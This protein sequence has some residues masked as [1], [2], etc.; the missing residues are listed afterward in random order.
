MESGDILTVRFRYPP[1]IVLILIGIRIK[2]HED[3]EDE[4]DHDDE[5]DYDHPSLNPYQW[6]YKFDIGSD[7]PI[8]KWISDIVNNFI[9]SSEDYNTVNIP[10]FTPKKF[11]VSSWNPNTGEGNTFQ[12]LGSNYQG[13]QIWKKQYFVVDKINQEYKLHIQHYAEHFVMQPAY[14]KGLFDILN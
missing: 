3:Y 13:S 4:E 6:Y 9:G 12:Y 10:G 5:H 2:M 11:P 7:T 14:Y 8:S 1:F